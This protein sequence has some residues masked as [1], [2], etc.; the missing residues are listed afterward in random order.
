MRSSDS[1][2]TK[3][4]TCLTELFA[5]L[6]RPENVIE[7]HWHNGDLVIWD[8]SPSS[9]PALRWPPT[10]R[11]GHCARSA[12]RYPPPARP[13]ADLPVDRMRKTTM[14]TKAV[15][16]LRLVVPYTTSACALIEGG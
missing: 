12:V 7:H 5:H 2:R 8:N 15:E 1:P 9:M 11:Q 14:N 4:R 16:A 3:V 6:Y 10:A 13:T